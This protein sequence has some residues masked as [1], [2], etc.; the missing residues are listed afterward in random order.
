VILL[1]DGQ[2]NYGA[3]P[4]AVA[5]ELGQR[6]VP[7]FPVAIG[8]V[9]APPDLA[10]VSVRGPEHSV[11]KDVEAVVDVRFKIAGMREGD[12]VV[13]L[14]REGKERKLLAARTIH[15]AGKDRTYG[16]SFPIKFEDA[17]TQTITAV[18]RPA[19]PGGP[20]ETSQDNNRL[21]TTVSVADDR[22]KVLL[23]DGEARWEYH[24][25]ATALVRDRL[26]DLQ[27][28]VFTQ[29][30]LDERLTGDQGEKLGLPARKWP[31]GPDALADFQC[32]I[33]GDVDPTNL[34]LEQRQRL[35]R[36]V[37]DAG[38][39]LIVVAG[40]RFMPL[41]YP[42]T[43]PTGDADPLRRLLPIEAP[44]TLAPRTGFPL[45]LTA[46]GSE[47]RFM[48]LAADRDENRQLWAGYPRPWGWAIEGQAKPGATPLASWLDTADNALPASERESRHAV[49]VRQNYGFG[50]VL[51]VGIDSTWRWRFK[52]GDLYHHRFWGQ[53]I[54]WA[55][56]DKPLV[57][58]N[59]FVRFGTP[60]P[61]YRPGDAVE[62]VARLADTLGPLRPDLLA[63]ARVLKL[64][65]QAGGAERPV[66]LAPL[67]RRPAQP[68]VLEARVRDLPPGRYAV[69]LAIP[70]LADRLLTSPDKG[71]KPLR[72]DF[73]V[74]PPES[75]ETL[76]LEVNRPLLDDLAAASGGKVYTPLDVGELERLLVNRG[77]PHV[78]HHEQRLWQWW[79][80][81]ALV[82]ALLSV[83][84][85]LRKMAGL[86]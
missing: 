66:A 53:V 13:E 44:R 31:D 68:R 27:R 25:L 64:P 49:V 69:E 72:A 36:Y 34:P 30:R 47:T 12:F 60:Q 82:V 38:G 21:S 65:D 3:A 37:A 50:R 33:L 42:S 6:K 63:G 75:K 8:A 5:R 45:T 52:V 24:Y 77:I 81:L 22:A 54:R 70:D 51:F 61:V 59:T 84:W 48:E 58:G 19:A 71:G 46:A 73:S 41:A 10:L 26:I 56:S 74:L 83:E 9:E 2:H 16:E 20:K 28:V 55:A 40:K 15:H 29:P 76:D 17:G 57:V 62:V 43:A 35:E 11:F 78:E 14:F 86:P 85:A 7:V 18:I 79:G 39:T 32:V 80:F 1:T 67:E 4:A 23:V